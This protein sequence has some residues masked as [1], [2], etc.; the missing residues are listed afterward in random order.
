[1]VYNPF[2]EGKKAVIR[3]SLWQGLS[4][5]M[6]SRTFIEN[7]KALLG[8]RAKGRDVVR[9]EEGYQLREGAGHY[10]AVFKAEKDDIGTEN[11]Y[12]WDNKIRQSI[13]YRGDLAMLNTD[14]LS[15]MG[16]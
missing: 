2:F 6:G 10:K 8:F 5:I 12:S 3:E 15:L 16:D 4:G 9:G 7:V 1:L 11:T 13:T 14:A